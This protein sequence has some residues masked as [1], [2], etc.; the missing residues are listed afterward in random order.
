MTDAIKIVEYTPCS[1][2]N[3]Y[4]IQFES[5]KAVKVQTEQK[6]TTKEY[7]HS[8]ELLSSH[9]VFPSNIDA[10]MAWDVL[11]E[12]TGKLTQEEYN[13]LYNVRLLI[14]MKQLELISVLAKL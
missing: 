6:Q 7:F 3:M 5:G 12:T 8:A 10:N 13:L 2:G 4:I 1:D 9:A 14:V 11:K